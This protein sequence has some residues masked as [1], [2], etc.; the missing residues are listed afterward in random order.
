VRGGG[1]GGFDIGGS[2]GPT[3]IERHGVLLKIC[4]ALCVR[5]QFGIDAPW[6]S[7]ALP[8]TK[9]ECAECLRNASSNPHLMV[10]Y[11][12]NSEYWAEWDEEHPDL[13]TF[14]AG[15]VHRS[16]TPMHHDAEC[17]WRFPP[18]KLRGLR[19]NPLPTWCP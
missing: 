14:C 11:F 5:Q 2:V 17:R 18:R 8:L 7:G 9:A 4:R 1:H 16:G 15:V 6:Y 12:A 3:D 13:S 10:A 19:V